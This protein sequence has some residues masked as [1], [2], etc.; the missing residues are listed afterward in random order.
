MTYEEV[1][2]CASNLVATYPNDIEEAFV[3]EILQFTSVVAEA[4][5]QDS[6]DDNVLRLNELLTGSQGLMMSTFP[7]VGIVLKLY[8][9]LRVSNCEGERL[10]STV[11]RIKNHLR[12]S[13]CQNRLS[14]LSLLSIESAMS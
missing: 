11:S 2:K 12:S 5:S 3:N 6:H 4:E 9:T 14:A 1:N 7:N 10:F 8:L 13:I